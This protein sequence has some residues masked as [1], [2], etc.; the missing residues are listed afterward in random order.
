MLL[1]P[2]WALHFIINLKK[3]FMQLFKRMS[4]VLV[5]FLFLNSCKK[6][7]VKTKTQ[8]LTQK[9]WVFNKIEVKEGTANWLDIT[10]FLEPCFLDDQFIYNANGTYEFNEGATKCDNADPQ[11]FESGNWI[12]TNN[13][14]KLQL[15]LGIEDSATIEVLNENTLVLIREE[16]E[17]GVVTQYR[18]TFSHP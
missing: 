16:I 6:E 1:R 11:V 9:S 13:E 14:T 2:L 7:T 10:S 3:H 18:L 4:V 17:D 12:F 8:L 15:G 5:L